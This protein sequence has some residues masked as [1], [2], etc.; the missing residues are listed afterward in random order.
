[1]IKTGKT[2]YKPDFVTPP[3]ETIQEMLDSRGLSQ[4]DL[5]LRMGRPKKT[6]NEIIL[7]K[8]AITPDTARQ[9]ELVLNI[10]AS[11]WLMREAKY[12][13]W[14]IQKDEDQ[15]LDK[16]KVLLD[17]LPIS[18]MRSLGWLE[19]STDARSTVNSVLTFFSVVSLDKI[20]LVEEAAFRKSE[21]FAI[22]KWAL[23]AW[24]RKGEL[25]ANKIN[26]NP[27]NKD[28]FFQVLQKARKLTREE[29]ET[30]VPELVRICAEAG[31]CLAFVPELP[32]TAV[33]GA[34]RW[35][36]PEKAL[37][38]LSLRYKCNDMFWFTFFHEAGHVYLEHAKRE[39][40][41][42]DDFKGFMDQRE[43]QAN[44]FAT[45]FLI[46][47][48]SFAEFIQRGSFSSESI[49]KFASELGVASGIVVGRLQFEKVIPFSRF[50]ELKK[51]FS[52]E[53][54]P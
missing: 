2:E 7:G 41:L 22:N 51:N 26:C 6:I 23:A 30:F 21:K 50:R 48:E 38:Q 13:S 49:K 10:P 5:A 40:L 24:L 39:I 47:K 9:L 44:K 52:W 16:E 20:P 35:L 28:R 17:N 31:V 29:P 37:I 36:G 11:F 19:K 33:S 25:E 42:E 45:D 18:K 32:Q 15:H 27:Y 54:W 14:L 12:R 8:A 43:V 53:E 4:A 3:G 46:P 1:M 34:T